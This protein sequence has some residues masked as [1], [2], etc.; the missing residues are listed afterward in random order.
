MPLQIV[1]KWFSDG[2]CGGFMFYLSQ[3]QN[4]YGVVTK[5]PPATAAEECD[6]T[7]YIFMKL[8]LV[9]A[10]TGLGAS[11]ITY[12]RCKQETKWIAY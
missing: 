3:E 2:T 4:Q 11:I 10:W 9:W 5:R 8:D 6:E 7:L 1:T 12:S